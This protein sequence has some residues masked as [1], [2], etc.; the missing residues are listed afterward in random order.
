LKELR[1]KIEIGKIK[2]RD[3]FSPEDKLATKFKVSRIT[4]MKTLAILSVESHI[5][6]IPERSTFGTFPEYKK[7]ELI[8]NVR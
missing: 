3:K 5:Y 7:V 6:Q 8:K 1:K 2:E 4:L